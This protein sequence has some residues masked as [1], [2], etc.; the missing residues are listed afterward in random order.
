MLAFVVGA[1]LGAADTFG[2][3]FLLLPI[4]L[5]LLNGAFLGAEVTSV[6]VGL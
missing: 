5:V 2:A 6:G 3:G 4:L 1:F